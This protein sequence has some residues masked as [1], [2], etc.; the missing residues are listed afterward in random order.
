MSGENSITITKAQL[1]TWVTQATAREDLW[2]SLVDFVAADQAFHDRAA[3]LVSTVPTFDAS[4]A[5]EIINICAEF[6]VT[7]YS[8]RPYQ[9]EAIE[10]VFM[11]GMDSI[12]E[13]QVRAR[14]LRAVKEKRGVEVVF[15]IW[16]GHR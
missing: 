14:I 3:P 11:Q 13:Q 8:F 6:G 1:L 2:K 15:S 5:E 9:N 12:V 16:D 4:M 10:V 7:P